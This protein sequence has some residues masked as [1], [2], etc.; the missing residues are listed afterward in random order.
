[1]RAAFR[2]LSLAVL[3][4]VPA[5]AQEYRATLH[6]T[7]WNPAGTPASSVPLVVI[8]EATGEARHVMSDGEGRYAVVG[9]L[10]GV[11]RVETNDS[12]NP[13]FS[14]RA[15]VSISQSRQLD[16]RLGV[17]PIAADVDVRP[18]FIPIDGA[19]VLTAR[20]HGVLITRLPFDGRNFLEAALL[21][22]GAVPEDG[23]ISSNGLRDLFA[24]YLL[25][26]IYDIDPRLGTPAVRPQLDSIDEMEVRAFPLDVSFGRTGGA[27]VNVVTRSGTNELKGGVLGFFRSAGSRAQLGGF[28]GGP[29]LEN[30]TFLFGNYEFTGDS[31]ER[32]DESPSR[33]ASLKF[34]Q[35]VGE[36]SRMTA[37]YSLDDDGLFGRTGQNAGISLHVASGAVVNETRG[38]LSRI[39]FDGPSPLATFSGSQNYQL[40]N[41]TT[42]PLAAHLVSA[43]VEWYGARRGG[44]SDDLAG[45]VWGFFVQDEFR[46]VPSLTLT[47]GGR[48]DRAAAGDPEESE[49]TFSPRLGF[50][51]SVDDTGGTVVSGGYGLTRNYTM[52]D[53]AA[54]TVDAWRI[55]VTRHIG[56]SRAFEAA[57]VATRGEDVETLDR[58]T[59]YDAM[60]LQFEQRSETGLT[61]LVSY[62]Y[63]KWTESFSG[64]RD[65][66]S[67]LDSRHRL[68]TAFVETLPFG[69]DGRWFTDGIAAKIL[70]DL[71]LSGVF[72]L[73]S[74][75][76]VLFLGDAQGAGHRN[77]DV[78][79]IKSLPLAQRRTLQL[80][81][82]IFNLTNRENPLGADRRHQFG[83]RLLF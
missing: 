24:A 40:A 63:G 55:G 51:W 32:A 42:M 11:Y 18:T 46:A 38:G 45:S 74:G 36:S 33:L 65:I 54:P 44:D 82:E 76:P 64:G 50:A 60:Q 5:A 62:T 9:L 41:V 8:R 52:F 47:L 21:T 15:E 48:F 17:V 30:R 31:G 83:G 59:R 58:N 37:R 7:I 80:R 56:R 14:I 67:P 13:P 12:R 68:T 49:N 1:M 4:A 6:G 2:L 3:L 23:A 66:R 69:K 25:D 73:Q 43:G 19:A 79:L 77:L 71:E 28:A 29:V 70:G 57:Y 81:A 78:A 22:P 10:P 35:V 20:I 16:L 53:R 34:D 61:A 26:G 39:T 72:T 75:R 27:Q